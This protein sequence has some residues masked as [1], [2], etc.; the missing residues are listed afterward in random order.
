MARRF[1]PDAEGYYYFAKSD[2]GVVYG[3]YS[4]RSVAQ[5]VATQM[6]P[7]GVRNEFHYRTQPGTYR[8]VREPNPNYAPHRVLKVYKTKMN[9]MEPAPYQSLREKYENVA[10]K[11]ARIEKMLADR[12]IDI[13]VD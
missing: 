2:A 7:W 10:K 13:Q 11:L 5:G 8:T 9:D 4:S 12:G 1:S 6:T 3:P